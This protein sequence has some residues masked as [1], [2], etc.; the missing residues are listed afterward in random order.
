LRLV[1]V[2]GRP[3]RGGV[4]AHALAL[5]RNH[6][7]R[8]VVPA[9]VFLAS[10]TGPWENEFRALADI[11]VCHYAARHRFSFVLRLR[12]MLRELRTD[13]VICHAFG[14]HAPVALAAR[15]AGVPKTF[16]VIGNGAPSDSRRLRWA[17]R[18]A[19][20]GR[21]LGVKEIAVSRHVKEEVE[22]KYGP[23]KNPIMVINNGIDAAGLDTRL[24]KAGATLRIGTPGLSMIGRL[25]QIKDHRTLLDAA[26][27]AA[28]E[29]PGLR[30]KVVGDGPLRKEIEAQAVET[31]LGA[32]LE[33]ASDEP[34]VAT[35]L[36]A[37]DIFCFSTTA[38]EGFGIAIVEAMCA[39]LPII[40]TDIG[41]CREVLGGGDCGV[42]VPPHD[43]RAFADA[44]IALWKDEP[45]RVELGRKARAY[46]VENY[47][48][49]VTTRKYEALLDLNGN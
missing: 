12:R 34:D 8:R 3:D 2:L 47:D 20:L 4:E 36:R 13:A 18:T 16:V 49:R 40:A 32:A 27:G 48:A 15:L 19:R 38:E 29:L 41:P 45:R 1:H 11:R 46:A 44:I 28:K 30:L 17:R 23:P 22:T 42:L 33:L 25:D 43:P 37:T 24:A 21:L 14:L 39:G 9:V 31:G 26:A 6:D 5:L 7:K 35:V 10:D